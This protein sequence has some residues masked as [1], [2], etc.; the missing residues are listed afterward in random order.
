MWFYYTANL[1]RSQ[2]MEQ[3]WIFLQELWELIQ[4]W[5]W[6]TVLKLLCNFSPVLYILVP[7]KLYYK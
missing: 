3:N 1:Q 4:T 2:K 5:K 6:K 7:V